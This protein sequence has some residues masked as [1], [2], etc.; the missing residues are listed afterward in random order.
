MQQRE[1]FEPDEVRVS[2]PVR[3]QSVFQSNL[4]PWIKLPIAY[5]ASLRT[6]RRLFSRTTAM[7]E[8]EKPAATEAR[9]VKPLPGLKAEDIQPKTS[10][11]SVQPEPKL[12]EDAWRC[13]VTTTK[14]SKLLLFLKP[15]LDVKQILCKSLVAVA[16]RDNACSLPNP[17]QLYCVSPAETAK[18]H[19]AQC[20]DLGRIK[21]KYLAYCQSEDGD[22]FKLTN[23][24]ILQGDP[25]FLFC[26][27]LGTTVFSVSA[28]LC[29][30]LADFAPSSPVYL[31]AYVED[32]AVS[33]IWL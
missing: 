32:A 24:M 25:C 33:A 26:Y 27:V 6:T 21:C 4:V 19:N 29:F 7:V 23:D 17:N 30:S 28:Q 10:G 3:L 15:S 8:K 1:P 5:L 31:R 20:K 14:G 22:G 12:P 13:F 16:A 2:S 11:G 9:P 18:R